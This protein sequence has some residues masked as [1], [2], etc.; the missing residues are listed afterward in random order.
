MRV[1]RVRLPTPSFYLRASALKLT[2]RE[3]TNTMGGRFGPHLT[4]EMF[5]KSKKKFDRIGLDDDFESH[6]G[7]GSL[8]RAK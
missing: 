5:G 7:A 2:A 4:L 1:H 8:D 6:L 3:A